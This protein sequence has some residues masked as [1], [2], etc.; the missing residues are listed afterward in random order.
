ME[1]RIAI[2]SDIHGNY[3]ALNAV[4]RDIELRGVENIFDLGDSLYGPL[5]P[6][7]TYKLIK[8]KKIKSILGNQDRLII[9]NWKK[10][11]LPPTLAYVKS[12]IN[13]EVWDWL[14]GLP[15]TRSIGKKFFI[16]H[17]TP[18]S[19]EDYLISKVENK[20]IR[21]RIADDLE[22]DTLNISQRI[23]LCG[24]DHLPKTISI[25]DGKTLI[26]PGSVGLQAYTD[27][28][29]KKHSIQTCNPFAKYCIIEY[30][31][32]SVVI[33]QLSVHYDWEEAARCAEKNQRP[34]WARWLRTG[35]V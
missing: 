7:N 9:E 35:M 12:Q 2:L 15:S 16:C 21:P 8:K 29:P 34:D 32:Y 18:Y 31:E 19:D 25:N 24:H 11:K 17:G 5:D 33:E 6:K 20:N 28:H 27:K 4:I 23:I 13:Q 10:Q 1:N 30:D 14:S 22:S 3:W 26:N